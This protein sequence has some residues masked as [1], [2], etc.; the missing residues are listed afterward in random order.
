MV[1]ESVTGVGFNRFLKNWDDLHLFQPQFLAWF[2]E[3]DRK[4]PKSPH[5]YNPY[6]V[7]ST[8]REKV[9]Y[10][11]IPQYAERMMTVPQR[12]S[13]ALPGLLLLMVYSVVL[14]GITVVL[15]NRYDVR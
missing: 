3:I 11:E 14:F 10:D 1:S 15:F 2:K 13:E 8:S 9:K 12:L 5:W 6:E 7:C 4:D